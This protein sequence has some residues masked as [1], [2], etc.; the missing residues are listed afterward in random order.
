M[1]FRAW[2]RPKNRLSF[3]SSSH[4]AVE[5]FVKSVLHWLARRDIVP[6][7]PVILRPGEDSVPGELGAVVR[8]DH[9]WL[10]ALDDQFREFPG[11][12]TARDRGIRVPQNRDDLLFREPLSLHLA[13]LQSRP[14]L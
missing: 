13:V 10:A 2:P 6:F 14:A 4:P 7:D 8:D 1:T 11:N 5:A 3:R 9:A 12:P